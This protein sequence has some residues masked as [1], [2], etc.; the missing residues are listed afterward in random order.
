MPSALADCQQDAREAVGAV[1]DGVAITKLG[2][3]TAF[4]RDVEL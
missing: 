4:H 3:D 1:H 2:V